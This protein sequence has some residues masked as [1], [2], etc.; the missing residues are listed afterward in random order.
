MFVTPGGAVPRSPR[1]A[2][3]A[4]RIPASNGARVSA[5]L[6]DVALLLVAVAVL[7]FVDVAAHLDLAVVICVGVP[8]VAWVGSALLRADGRRTPGQV[9]A[10]T[11]IATGRSGRP[12]G[13]WRHLLRTAALHVSNVFAFAGALSVQADRGRP[14]RGWHEKLSGTTTSCSVGAEGYEV[15]T[16]PTARI[17][18]SDGFGADAPTALIDPTPGART[19]PLR[20]GHH[21]LRLR[22]DDGSFTDLSGAGYLGVPGVAWSHGRASIV[23]TPP[24]SP[25]SGDTQVEFSVADGKLWM[26]STGPHVRSLLDN[27]ESVTAM[28]P[29][30]PY[31]VGPGTVVHLGERS[32]EVAR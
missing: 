23:V 5:Y 4:N 12:A 6:V 16:A 10:K 3:V 9:L 8:L 26:I 1:A 28:R 18:P 31:E 14:R 11:T 25:P 27:G 29:G 19:L 24:D 2:L 32:F 22:L 13:F 21:R 20:R 17:A 7:M 30:H 15:V